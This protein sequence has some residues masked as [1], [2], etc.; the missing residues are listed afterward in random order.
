MKN[1][2][3]LRALRNL[4]SQLATIERQVHSCSYRDN[5]DNPDEPMSAEVLR[6]AAVHARVLATQMETLAGLDESGVSS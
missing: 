4:L 1:E 3:N 6:K 5:P 2:K